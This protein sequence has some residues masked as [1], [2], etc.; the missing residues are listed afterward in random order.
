MR[1][2]TMLAAAGIVAAAVAGV[3]AAAYAKPHNGRGHAAQSTRG[4]DSGSSWG[5]GSLV[6]GW[7]QGQAEAGE[8]RGIGEQVSTAAHDR[9]AERKAA[10]E[11]ERDQ[12]FATR[13]AER[14]Q[15]LATRAERRTDAVRGQGRGQA[16]ATRGRG[17]GRG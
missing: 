15:R 4:G 11:A 9:N 1:K 17:R 2:T 12:R 5:L 16:K 7:A 8:E 14:D 6:R 13:Q 3:G 10:H